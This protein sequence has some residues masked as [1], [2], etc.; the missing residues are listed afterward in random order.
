MTDAERAL[1]ITEL[2]TF[3]QD[4]S[5]KL[6]R[7]LVIHETKYF[8]FASD[9]QQA[10]AIAWANLLDRMYNQLSTMFGVTRGENIWR[11]K[12]IVLVFS[13]ADDYRRYEREVAHV[14]PGESAGMCH[15]FGDGTVKIAFYR[16]PDGLTFAHVLVHESVHGFLHRY[17]S[18]VHIP[19]WL[20]E[21]LAE[22]ISGE[23]VTQRGRPQQVTEYA[24]TGII[25]HSNSLGGLCDSRRLEGWQYP[26]AEKLT[27]FMIAQNRRNYVDMINGIKDGLSWKDSLE[28]KYKAPL[29]KIVAFFG[30]SLNV[31]NVRP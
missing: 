13:R 27:Q 23:L 25:D 26:V 3:A 2:K 9:L 17:R 11:G 7:P 1:A 19:S 14:D 8:L 15:A 4:T 29:D 28:Q 31:K 10:E 21:G 24:R 5:K 16:Q 12:A 20:N 22:T 30:M 6:Q 18:P